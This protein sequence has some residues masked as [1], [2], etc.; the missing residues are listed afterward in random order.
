MRKTLTRTCR[1]TGEAGGLCSL[2]GTGAVKAGAKK[3]ECDR[4]RGVISSEPRFVRPASRRAA[5]AGG[6][7]ERLMQWSHPSTGLSEAVTSAPGAA[8][9]AGVVCMSPAIS[10]AA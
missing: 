3:N 9:A 1:W 5:V 4:A 8:S 10:C 7:E 6:C 2:E